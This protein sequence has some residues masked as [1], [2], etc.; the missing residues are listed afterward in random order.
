MKKLRV[1]SIKTVILL[2]GCLLI[3]LISLI[4]LL[5]SSVLTNKAFDKQIKEDMVVTAGFVSDKIIAEIDNSEK[6][7]KELS[8]QPMLTN[9]DFPKNELVDFY[10]K[11]AKSTGFKLF[12]TVDKN[13]DGVN[14]TQKA[15]TFNVANTEYFKQSIQGNTY[16]SSVIDDVVSG[17]KIFVISTP[18]YDNKTGELLGIFA[19][20]KD[21]DFISKICGEFKWG[22]TGNIAVYDKKTSILGHTD[23]KIVKSNLNL[24]EKA[25]SDPGYK[26]VAEFFKKHIDNKTSGVGE[27]NWFGKKRIGVINNIE[28]RDIITL[29]A[30][31]H[32]EVF[33]NLNKLQIQLF[34]AIV[35]LTLLAIAIIYFTFAKNLE[36]VFKNIKTDLLNISNYDLS[37]EPTKDYSY[38]KDEIGDI[39][40]ATITLKENIVSIISNIT[41]HAQNT[42]ATAQELTAT[43]QSTS[44][45]ANEVAGAVSN[46][47]QG[48][49][50]QAE[51]T[52][53]A[54]ENVE[55][56][57]ELLR[58][59]NTV[60]E[61]LYK[62]TDFIN[63][64]KEEGS[65]SI[66]E[67]VD[68]TNKVRSSSLEIAEIIAQTNKSAEQISSASDM[69]QSISD[70]T[71]L[72]A[73]NAAIEAARAGEAGK[74]F[75]VVADEIRK[76]AE[77]SAGFTGD[78]KQTI[79]S[80]QEKTEKAV[81]TMNFAQE[82]V[83]E[84]E[85]KLG[86]TEEK[87]TQI[88][89]ALEKSKEIVNEIS[90]EANNL[91]DNNGNITKIV[92]NLSAIAQENAATTQ[93]AA[94]SVD[95]QVQ[96]IR[97]ISQ[98][99]ENLAEIATELQEEVS[100]FIL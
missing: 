57:N 52:Q 25:A 33:N 53:N 13:G 42:A 88:S 34:I 94:A 14:L 99:S 26:S 92:E 40:R 80:L 50:S 98:A 22:T 15:E 65:K 59:M 35:I 12:F 3:G 77:Q 48:A 83:S 62:S 51:D 95:A 2:G 1:K 93:E 81:D 70:Q 39:Y 90:E 73:L 24:I 36:S 16:T 21:I 60:L 29:V 43:A 30:I 44:S 7:V 61:E 37:K 8:E 49:S 31:N 87:F 11:R 67:L 86:E 54:A 17:D 72:L 64:K 9:K 91:V 18:Y 68:A 23:P 85:K 38:R 55:H 27:Y 5:M 6:I 20:I 10:E 74:G 41:S 89:E 71:N 47:A 96:S 100:K 78:I 69:I 97:D 32:G 79:N 45:S 46:I 82:A 4:I 76:L 58:E 63:E 28:N 66:Q 19:G 56:S 84:Q 75:A